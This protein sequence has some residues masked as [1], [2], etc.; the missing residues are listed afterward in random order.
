MP[1]R[2]AAAMPRHVRATYRARY[3]SDAAAGY[4]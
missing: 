1:R 2:A 4:Y 3:A